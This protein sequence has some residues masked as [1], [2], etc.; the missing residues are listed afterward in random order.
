MMSNIII[1]ITFLLTFTL[2]LKKNL[3]KQVGC[4]SSSLDTSLQLSANGNVG[5]SIFARQIGQKFLFQHRR[6]ISVNNMSMKKKLKQDK[7]D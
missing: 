6:D 7:T 1:S 5:V 3:T 2:T 4:V